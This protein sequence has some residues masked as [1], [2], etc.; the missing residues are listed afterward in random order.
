M[1]I[2]FHFYELNANDFLQIQTDLSL[3]VPSNFYG[4]SIRGYFSSVEDFK[5]LAT[6]FLKAK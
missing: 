5:S 3:V 1:S 2:F 4:I 6:F